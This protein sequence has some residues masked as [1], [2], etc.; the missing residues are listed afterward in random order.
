MSSLSFIA[1]ILR[2]KSN[3]TR[4]KYKKKDNICSTIILIFQSLII[5]HLVLVFENIEEKKVFSF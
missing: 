5:T 3:T 1:K 2:F 4:K